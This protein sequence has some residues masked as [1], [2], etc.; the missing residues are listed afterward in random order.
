MDADWRTQSQLQPAA[1]GRMVNKITETLMKHPLV[2]A[3]PPEALIELQRIAVRFEDK[4]YAAATS[5]SDYF[6]KI[7]L[8]LMSLESQTNTQHNPQVIPIQ[9]PPGPGDFQ[10]ELYQTIK[11]LKDQYFAELSDLYGKISMKIQHVDN[12]MP[13]QKS[14][15]Q[16][17]KMKNF[18][19]LLERTLHFLQINKSS[20]QRGLREKIPIYERQIVSILNSQRRKPVQAP[21]QQQFQQS[22]GQAPNSNISQ[23]HQASQG[24]QQ[25]DSHANQIAVKALK[26]LSME[27]Q[28]NTQHNP[29]VIPIQK[30][31]GPASVDLTCQTGH[32]GAC[33]F[34]EELYQTIK[35]LKDQYFAELSDLYSKISIKIQ[36]VDNHM[37]AQKSTDQ[38]EK[39]KNFKALL[40][41]TLHFL[42][43]NKSSIQP[44]LREKIPIYERQIVSILNSQRRKPV[45]APGQQQFQQ[46]GGQAPSF[47]ILQQHQ[48]SQGLQQ[49]DSHVNQIAVQALKLLS[50]ES[51]TN[52]QHNSQVIPIQKPPGPGLQQHD[53]H[54]NQIA[55]QALKLLSMESQTNTQHNSQV[56]PIQKPLG[57]GSSSKGKNGK[58]LRCH[59][60]KKGGHFKKDCPRKKKWFEMKGIAYDRTHKRT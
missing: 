49:H 27:S 48:A 44:G 10:E 59:F 13:A 9:K 19:A 47:N 1:R 8:K 51:Q 11:S 25:H 33:D 18:K 40:E 4:M 58:K 41:R 52:T 57:P 14:S 28:T 22:G 31:P 35:S 43:I 15:D 7:A 26:L 50:M 37:P 5:Q 55:V 16:Y 32:P 6:H 29:Q 53:S 34:Q 56:I 36:H 24:L 38:Y 3:P 39:M 42:Q 54:A 17:E 45:Q 60:C 23:Q 12:H 20:I 2:S 46:S 30:P 21:G